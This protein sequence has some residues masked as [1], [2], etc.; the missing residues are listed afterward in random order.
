[1]PDRDLERCWFTSL[2]DGEMVMSCFECDR[3]VLIVDED[4]HDLGALVA[5]A[6]AHAEQHHPETRPM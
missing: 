6:C 5:A 2:S 3:V 4:T 1:M